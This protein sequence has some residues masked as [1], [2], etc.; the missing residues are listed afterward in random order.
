MLSGVLAR[1]V[2]FYLML[3]IFITAG[4]SFGAHPLI[5]DDTGTQGKGK[6]QLEFNSEVAWDKEEEDGVT[7]RERGTELEWVVSYGV[8]DTV[9]LVLTVPYSWVRV[10]EGGEVTHGRGIGDMSFEVKWRFYECNG[11]SLAVKPGL[12]FPTGD[13]DDGEGTGKVGGSFFLIATQELEPFTFHVNLGY[14]R[15]ENDF[16]EERDLWHAS[17]AGEY[18]LVK[19]LKWVA[20]LGAEGNTDPD[21]DTPPV[22]AITGLIYSITENLDV[23]AG[24]KVGLTDPEADVALLAGLAFRF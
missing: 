3:T 9:D 8:V 1:R 22:F 7:T 11:L 6:F 15:N 5:T 23:D 24:V 12:S 19:D 21:D 16:G 4:T 14:M 20:N 2:V 17:I 18:E 10:N 13:E